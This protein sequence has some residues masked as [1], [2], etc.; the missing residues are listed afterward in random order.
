MS[1]AKIH[2]GSEMIDKL[3][4]SNDPLQ[5]MEYARIVPLLDE[6]YRLSRPLQHY[7]VAMI[8]FVLFSL[9]IIDHLILGY[10]PNLG[11]VGI[12]LTLVKAVAFGMVL[13]MIDYFMAR[14][15]QK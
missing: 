13:Y 11:R 9:S 14:Y 1:A 5:P 6:G 10:A 8:L 12:L 7:V 2:Y 3:P 15:Q 4:L